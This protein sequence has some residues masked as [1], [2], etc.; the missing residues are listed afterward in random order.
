VLRDVYFTFG[1][2]LYFG[3]AGWNLSDVDSGLFLPLSPARSGLTFS[4]G[5][6]STEWHGRYIVPAG[7]E[8]W[9][10]TGLITGDFR[11]FGYELTL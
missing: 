1:T 4:A 9:A 8:L 10:Y 6:N 7:G 11:F 3:K 2:F 5:Y